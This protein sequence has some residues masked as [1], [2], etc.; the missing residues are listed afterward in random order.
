MYP[1]CG[2][3]PLGRTRPSRTIRR[4]QV[5]AAIGY[6]NDHTPC[7]ARSTGRGRQTVP[8]PG[9]AFPVTSNMASH[10]GPS[11]SRSN[12][13]VS[14]LTS[15]AEDLRRRHNDSPAPPLP[16]SDNYKAAVTGKSRGSGQVHRRD[17]SL[18]SLA[19]PLFLSSTDQVG[20]KALCLFQ[21]PPCTSA[22]FLN[23]NSSG[24]RIH[25]AGREEPCVGCSSALSAIPV[26]SFSSR[27][28]SIA[29]TKKR[30]VGPLRI[31]L[32]FCVV[33]ASCRVRGDVAVTITG[34]AFRAFS[35]LHPLR[36]DRSEDK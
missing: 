16:Q 8:T 25:H 19:T 23:L 33:T 29:I 22:T 24:G 14:C 31:L 3:R 9:R 18:A 32:V 13:S 21:V 35:L 30:K 11:N 1:L 36:E 2:S 26:A 12:P 28:H 4:Q 7:R 6:A 5:A 27:S 20:R 15:T 34:E 10:S 17:T